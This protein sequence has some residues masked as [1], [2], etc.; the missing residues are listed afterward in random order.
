LQITRNT[1]VGDFALFEKITHIKLPATEG[2]NI[3]V[4][5]IANS[6]GTFLRFRIVPVSQLERDGP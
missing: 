6:D 2:E 4:E 5:Y 1:V 3:V